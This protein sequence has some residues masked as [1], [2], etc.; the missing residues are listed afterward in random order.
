MRVVAARFSKPS[1]ASVARELLRRELD[2]PEVEVAPLA[3]PGE[4][5]H[6]EA[7]LAGRFPDEVAPVAVRLVVR[8]GGEIVA[9]I[10]E[11][12]TGLR[13]RMQKSSKSLELEVAGWSSG[14]SSGS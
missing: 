1:D 4:A 13:P 5:G 9:D 3:H 7:L 8:A 6:G 14:S 12:W 11:S 10:D 2:P